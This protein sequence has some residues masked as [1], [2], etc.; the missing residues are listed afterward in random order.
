MG[1]DLNENRLKWII[2]TNG[3]WKKSKS[4][5]LFWSYWLD[6]TANLAHLPKKLAK[7]GGAV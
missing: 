2:G 4:W 5:G 1:L 6:S 7:R 3:N